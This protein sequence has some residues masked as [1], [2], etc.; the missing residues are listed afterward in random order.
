[1]SH[2]ISEDQLAT[3]SEYI[4]RGR[5]IDAIKL[6]REMTG[7]GLK[8]AKDAVEELERTLR[9]SSPGSFVESPQGKGCLGVI[10]VGL[11]C[12]GLFACWL[13]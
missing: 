6:Y 5:K 13:A 10:V 1:M 7:F 9:T 8:E 4:T 11:L 3:L 12:S 2:P